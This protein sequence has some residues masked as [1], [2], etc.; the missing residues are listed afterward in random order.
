MF[1]DIMSLKQIPQIS[2]DTMQSEW[3]SNSLDD[4]DHSSVL[5]V[6]CVAENKIKAKVIVAR[7]RKPNVGREQRRELKKKKGSKAKEICN[8]L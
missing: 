3:N 7:E 4:Y 8:T 6:I 2:S 5:C 1:C